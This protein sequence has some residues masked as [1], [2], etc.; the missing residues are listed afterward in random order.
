VNIKVLLQDVVAA[1]E[2]TLKQ[3]DRLLAEMTDEVGELVLRDNI[4]QNLAL[5]IGQGLGPDLVDA[6]IR[7]MRRLE[8]A[9]RLDRRIEGLPS[10]AALLERRKAAGV[11]LTRPRRRCCSPTPR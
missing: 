2:L 8:A 11:G 6:Q 1:G 4:L 9:G 7:L 3:R 5:S 10:D